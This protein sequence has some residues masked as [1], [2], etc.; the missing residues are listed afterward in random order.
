MAKTP[1]IPIVQPQ[2]ET[3]APAE[4]PESNSTKKDD[5]IENCDDRCMTIKGLA[6]YSGYSENTIR[7]L[8]RRHKLPQ[9]Y[10]PTSKPIYRKRDVDKWILSH[11]EYDRKRHAP[12]RC[13]HGVSLH[14]GRK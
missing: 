13:A 11:R 9:A 6:R 5:W 3:S 7:A 14:G 1:P 4:A 12:V 8:R 10:T 2:A